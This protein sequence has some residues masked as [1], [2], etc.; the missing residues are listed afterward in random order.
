M[1]NI[2]KK[3]IINSKELNLKTYGK[4][5]FFYSDLLLALAKRDFKVRYA[6]TILG[7]LWAIINPVI[8]LLVL[9]F[10]FDQIGHFDT[11]T[12]PSILFI[13]S[14]V[15]VWNFF[16]SLVT[17][18]A[19]SIIDNQQM[20]KKIYFPRIILPL[21]KI[22]TALIDLGVNF[23]ILILLMLYYKIDLSINLFFLPLMLVLLLLTGLLGG[24]FISAL[25]V[26]YRDLRFVVPLL[27]R[28]GLFV[29]PVGY[30]ALNVPDRFQ[31][32][33]N[34]NPLVIVIDSFRWC[35]FGLGEMNYYWAYS[36]VVLLILLTFSLWYFLKVEK[37]MS[38]IL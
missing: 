38:D 24:V 35:M 1:R 14:G 6:Q 11:G 20:V 18:S 26:K 32:W 3:S 22:P 17:D 7:F 19:N 29:S 31:F 36:F 12:V 8:T 13:M 10:V 28:I 37:F 33:Y 21:S 34:L 15:L 27:L 5:V 30:S 4:D 9:W 25:T 2:V 23:A 16:S